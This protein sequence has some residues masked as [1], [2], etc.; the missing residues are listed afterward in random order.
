MK[1]ISV[2]LD[3]FKFN[4]RVCCLIEN[5]NRYLLERSSI[6][7]FLNMPGGRVKAGENTL[8]AIKRELLEEIGI[9]DCEPK[10]LK[11][12]E[13]FFEFDNKKY[14]ELDFIYYLYL[15]DD[16]EF[17]KMDVIKNMDNENEEMI[18]VDVKSLRNYKILPELIYDIKNSNEISHLIFD[19][20]KNK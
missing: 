9:A 12:A 4:F 17:A 16:N 13:Q 1:D 20:L 3:D 19:K 7:D 10:L 8:D 14:H 15:S 2:F 5:N 11:V 18:W 6:T